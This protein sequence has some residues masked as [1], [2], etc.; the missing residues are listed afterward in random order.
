M[1]QLEATLKDR[2]G[3]SAADTFTAEP[4]PIVFPPGPGNRSYRLGCINC[5]QGLGH[6]SPHNLSPVT[7][8][9]V[10]FVFLESILMCQTPVRTA[11]LVIYCEDSW[12]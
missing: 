1:R 2:G 7:P 8:Y 9:N 6:I 4:L 10:G 5:S 11:V 12:R 3:F